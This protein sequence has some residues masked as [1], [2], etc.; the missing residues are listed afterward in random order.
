[1]KKV[2]LIMLVCYLHNAEAQNCNGNNWY[3]TNDYS[4]MFYQPQPPVLNYQFNN[5][6]NNGGNC[7]GFNNNFAARQLGR[8][9]GNLIVSIQNNKRM[10]KQRRRYR[11]NRHNN[12]CTFNNRARCCR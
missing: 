8:S 7:N 5:I 12:N 2:F 6:Y 10:R 1:M 11:N 3:N 9:I 4:Y